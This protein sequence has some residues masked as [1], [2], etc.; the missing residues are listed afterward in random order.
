MYRGPGWG[1][2]FF[3]LSEF[4]T[5]VRKTFLQEAKNAEE[6]SHISAFCF[7]FFFKWNP[8]QQG[9]DD[10]RVCSAQSTRSQQRSS[11]E[12]SRLIQHQTL[13]APTASPS[14]LHEAPG[15][16][17]PEPN[18][19]AFPVAHLCGRSTAGRRP[20]LRPPHFPRPLLQ[21]TTSCQVKREPPSNEQWEQSS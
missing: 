17:R 11:D 5:T 4:A 9:Q 14:R 2:F 12:L 16:A 19:P 8:K 13:A 15:Q 18:T 1:A 10:K 20:T 6:F 3:F 21:A 7:F